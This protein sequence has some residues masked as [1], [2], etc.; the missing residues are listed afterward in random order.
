MW[1]LSLL[2]GYRS[3]TN[4]WHRLCIDLQ[5]NRNTEN[6]KSFRSIYDELY[7]V[8]GV[9]YTKLAEQPQSCRGARHLLCQ[10][11]ARRNIASNE[12]VDGDQ[13]GGSVVPKQPMSVDREWMNILCSHGRDLPVCC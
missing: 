3:I 9:S 11:D 4:S 2:T 8:A 6:C 12:I 13:R 7:K 1:V 10:R 5:S